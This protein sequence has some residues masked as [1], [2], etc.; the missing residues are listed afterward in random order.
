MVDVLQ[1]VAIIGITAFLYFLTLDWFERK[2]S[3][4]KDSE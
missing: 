2:P 4:D 1:T 3:K